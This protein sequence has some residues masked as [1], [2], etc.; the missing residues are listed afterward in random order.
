M[1]GPIVLEINGEEVSDERG[2]EWSMST[3][4]VLGGVGD[5]QIVVQDRTNTYEPEVHWDVKA[6]IRNGPL[7]GFVIWRGEIITLPEELPNKEPWR[8]W[9]ISCSDYGN[10]LDWRL[11]GA[12]DGQTWIDPEGFGFFVNIDPFASTLTTDKLTVQQLLDHYIRVNGESITTADF[13]YEYLTDVPSKTWDY[14]TLQRALE[15]LAAMVNANVQFWVDPD[16][17]FHWAAIP[18]WQDLAQDAIFLDENPSQSDLPSMFPEATLDLPVS[19]YDASDVRDETDPTHIGFSDLKFTL[20]GSSMPEQV[21]VRGSTGYVY[22]SP[23]I[24]GPTED[25]TVVIRPTPGA[26]ATYNLT[27]NGSTKVWHLSGGYID[28]SFDTVGAGG[29]Y[30]VKWVYI[31]WNASRNK[32]GNF[33]KLLSGPHSGKYVDN[34]TNVLSGYGSITV[35]RIDTTADPG[36]PQVGVGGSGFVGEVDQDL[37]KRQAFLEAAISSDRG[38]RDAIGGQALYRGAF[39]TLRGSIKARGVDG[40]R[41]GQLLPIT[42]ARLPSY[43]NGRHFVIQRVRTTL[44]EATDLREYVLDFGDGPTSRYSAEARQ[45][46]DVSWPPGAIQIDVDLKDLSPGPNTTQVVTAQLI[47]PSG[48]PWAVQGKVVEWTLEAYNNLGVIQPGLGTIAPTVS[49]T[50]KYGK[51]RTKMTSGATTNIVYFVFARVKVT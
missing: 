49:V 34:D 29:P 20:D 3:E 17:K 12:L 13:V 27:F 19:P 4:E 25:K 9:K 42:D 51:A 44:I 16:L 8:K 35:E 37:N 26:N 48:K 31:P 30:T 11:V 47:D 28:T 23:P 45:S 46:G 22:N 1:S 38:T 2:M 39:P 10:E 15:E 5:A 41:V 50:D 36:D 33:W 6:S 40:W 7:A 43:L 18:A 24:A 14:T 32:G 21:Y